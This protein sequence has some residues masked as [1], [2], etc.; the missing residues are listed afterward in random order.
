MSTG[1]ASR[2]SV[3]VSN[4]QITKVTRRIKPP[5]GDGENIACQKRR[6]EHS[7][8]EKETEQRAGSA[9]K[10]ASSHEREE[11]EPTN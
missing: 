1:G 11:R 9:T 6:G 5:R 8:R 7:R 10:S 2:L 3:G 4:Y